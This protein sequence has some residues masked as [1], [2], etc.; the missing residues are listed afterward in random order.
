MRI[1]SFYEI[2]LKS[3]L[4]QNQY[5]ELFVSLPNKFKQINEDTI[6]TTRYR[7][8][9]IRLRHS[10]K[11]F[12]IISKSGDPTK[13]ARKETK[14]SLGSIKQVNFFSKL[15]RLINLQKDPPW[16]KHKKEFELQ[17]NGHTYVI[18]L[19][20]IKDFAYI[21]EV[22]HISKKNDAYLHENNLKT[23]IKKLGCETINPENFTK[24]IEEY[25]G[26]NKFS[27]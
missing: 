8:G 4:S 27:K 24:R 26:A 14:I 11:I 18:C 21:L 20:N 3:L 12:E 2:E 16:I 7:P 22:E 6:H 5:E 23:I 25:V 19:Q 13:I 10:D 9:D 17:Y 1:E 15:F